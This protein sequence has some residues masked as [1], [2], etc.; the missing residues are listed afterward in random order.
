MTCEICGTDESVREGYCYE[1]Q[2]WIEPV[3]AFM[4]RVE[5]SEDMLD[6][7]IDHLAEPEA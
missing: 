1:C 6:R 5:V 7:L 3:D 2:V 4:D